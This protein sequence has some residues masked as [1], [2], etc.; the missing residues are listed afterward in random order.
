MIKVNKFVRKFWVEILFVC[1]SFAFS[2]WL[3]WST[4]DYKG[5]QIFV[6][7]KAWS[8]FAAHIP[9]IRSFSFGFNFPP[10]YPLFSGEPIRYHFLFFAFVGLFE[11]IG[12]PLNMALNLPSSF[13]FMLLLN[14]IFFAA[15]FLF[16]NIF[17]SVV[18]VILFLFNSSLS[19]LYFFANHSVFSLGTIKE[20]LENNV[21]PAFAPYDKSFI[22]GGFWNLNVFTNQRHLALSLSLLL[23]LSFWFLRSIKKQKISLHQSII[24]GVIIGCLPFLHGAVFIMATAVF[25]SFFLLFNERKKIILILVVSLV[26]ATPQLLYLRSGDGGSGLHFTPGYLVFQ[27]LTFF[28]FFR[29]WFLNMGLSFLLLPLGLVLADTFSRKIYA[30]FFVVFIIGNLFQFGPDIATNHKFFNLWIIINNIFVA[31]ALWIIWK[32]N[33]AAKFLTVIFLFILTLSG[34]IDFFPIKNDLLYAVDDLPRNKEASWIATHTPKNALFL[35][36][37]Y[38][39][40]PAS[41]AGRRIFLGWPYF[42]WSAGYNTDKRE[43]LRRQLLGASLPGGKTEICALL[44]KN[45]IGYAVLQRTSDPEE[46]RLQ[47]YSFWENNFVLVYQNLNKTFLIYDVNLSC[48]K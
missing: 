24:S 22:S 16:K 8:D 20:I 37:T 35:N 9:L 44:E 34:I 17:V 48:H 43:L 25:S 12:L 13:S 41:L 26:I 28:T 19:F 10:E 46:T 7:T 2:W 23:I 15:R 29:Y 1:F 47:N 5:D 27:N 42:P 3:M 40:H 32:K 21:F 6:A 36:A 14:T 31:Y 45:K 33:L 38:L 4:F 18:S 11:K 39:Y 30:A